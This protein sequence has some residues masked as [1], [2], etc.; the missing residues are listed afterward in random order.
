MTLD[1]FGTYLIND[2]N[3]DGL[4]DIVF[5]NPRTNMMWMAKQRFFGP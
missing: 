2:I 4:P 5:V 3:G 1:Q